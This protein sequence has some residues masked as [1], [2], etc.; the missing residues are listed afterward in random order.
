MKKIINLLM[1]TLIA[2]SLVACGGNDSEKTL[3]L[4][5]AEEAIM[6]T[7]STTFN[8]IIATSEV[9]M[10]GDLGNDYVYIYDFDLAAHNI[11][12]E[13]IAKDEMGMPIFAYLLNE[14]EGKLLFVAKAA[15]DNLK[16]EVEANIVAKYPGAVMTDV[17]G[18]IVVA[19]TEDSNKTI[20]YLKEKGY[21][22]VFAN[23]MFS[24]KEEAEFSLGVKPEFIEEAL[25]GLPMFMTQANQIIVIKPTEGHK[26]DVV[27]AMNFYMESLQAQWDTYLADQADLVRN[28][29]ETNIGDYLVYI[30]SP[31]NDSILA[32]LQSCVK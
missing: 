3:D 32:A 5:A 22:P 7:T 21:A 12:V 1:I 24:P 9:E 14:T 15:N 19:A 11:N 20:A 31:N 17:E 8:M 10:N 2:L 16:A 28:R 23:V 30:V 18:Y 4:T 26:D 29:L 6:A 25:I 13:N 27:E